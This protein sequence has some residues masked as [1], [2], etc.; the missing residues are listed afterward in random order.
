MSESRGLALVTGASRGLGHA[1]AEALSADGYIVVGLARSRPSEVGACAE[2]VEL[3]VTDTPAVKAAVMRITRTAGPVTACINAAGAASMNHFLTT[4]VETHE[5]L[6]RVN[7]FG[8]VAMM[9]AVTPGM[10]RARFGRI[11][12]FSTVAVG[13]DLA[14]EAA[15]VA[16]K[17]ALEAMTRVLAHELGGFGITVN[18]VAPPPIATRLLAGVPD[19]KVEGLVGRQA[20][21]RLGIADDVVNVVRF[22][23][24]PASS[25]VTGQTIRIGVPG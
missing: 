10:V 14:G 8:A 9:Q 18:A 21:K 2:F 22:F 3:D 23:L 5:R 4:P 1:C 16:S 25:M 24:S 11:V 6:M 19:D 20:I 7:H 12:N 13:Y 17:A 15:Y